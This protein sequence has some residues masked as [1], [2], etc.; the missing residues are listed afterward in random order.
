LRYAE[1]LHAPILGHENEKAG[2]C[3]RLL[4]VKAI[5]RAKIA[6]L[7]PDWRLNWNL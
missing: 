3:A 7:R 1:T 4:L 2:Q 5:R 6:K